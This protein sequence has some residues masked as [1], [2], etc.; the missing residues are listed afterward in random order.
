VRDP[1][2]GMQRRLNPDGN[3]RLT[4]VV[5]ILLLAPVVVELATIVLGVHTFMS[6]AATLV[7]GLVIGAATVPAQHHWMELPRD[8]DRGN[9]SAAARAAR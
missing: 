1:G 6:L 3:A 8:H 2:R 5:G 4:A 9:H 7:G